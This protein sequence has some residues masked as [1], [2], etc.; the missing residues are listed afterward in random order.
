MKRRQDLR[1]IGR[2]GRGRRDVFG[3]GPGGVEHVPRGP[4]GN[5]GRAVDGVAQE[6]VPQVGQGRANLVEK[7]G[8][9]AYL[10]E[11]RIGKGLEYPERL[12]DTPYAARVRIGTNTALIPDLDRIEGKIASAL[13]RVEA[14]TLDPVEL[15]ALLS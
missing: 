1:K 6:R 12:G 14:S 2:I 4:T 9:G 11:T 5:R 15:P 13:V 7:A 10:H 8:A 3:L